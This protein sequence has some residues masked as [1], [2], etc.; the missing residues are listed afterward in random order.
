MLTE[1]GTP[2]R[3]EAW[4]RAALGRSERIMGFGHR[5][6]KVRDPRAAV[7]VEAAEKLA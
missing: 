3:A 2:D 4:V 5:I 1:I 7:V 6:Y